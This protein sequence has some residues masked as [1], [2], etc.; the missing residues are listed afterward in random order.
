M[1]ITFRKYTF[2]KSRYVKTIHRG[3]VYI[4]SKEVIYRLMIDGR[5]V[6]KHFIV[7]L[8]WAKSKEPFVIYDNSIFTFFYETLTEAKSELAAKYVRHIGQN[9]LSA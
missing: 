1:K 3:L 6:P 5:I 9:Y 7:D 8:S 2:K 4:N